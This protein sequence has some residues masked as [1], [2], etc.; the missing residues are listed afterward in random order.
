MILFLANIGLGLIWAIL[1]GLFSPANMAI[2][3]FLGYLA[4]LSVR[5][6]LKPSQYF[7]TLPRFF[8]FAGYFALELM[9][10]NFRLAVDVLTPRH[11]MKPRV[12][13]VP[14]DVRTKGE[15]TLLA[16]LISLTPG[17]LSLDVS[18]DRKVLYVHAM[19]A[20]DVDAVRQSIKN[21]LERRVIELARGSE[22]DRHNG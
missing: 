1:T 22:R 9:L 8:E 19:Y 7:S 13:S 20:S 17:S 10:A 21:G 2:G 11:R 16:N 18:P 15:I 3:F 5:S 12:L 14:L 4:L 6:I